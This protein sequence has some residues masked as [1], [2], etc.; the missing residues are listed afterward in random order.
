M[1]AELHARVAD[2][3]ERRPGAADEI[4][5]YHLE[6]ACLLRRE[7]G[8]TASP[9]AAGRPRRRALAAP[10]SQAAL[11]RGDPAAAS[12]LLERAIALVGA[13]D[14]ARAAL[15]PALGASL[16]EAGPA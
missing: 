6:Q 3:L 1:R 15:L 9:S 13:D 12:A 11:G 4:V 14:A 16:F 2:W 5:G 10:A 7:L 8:P